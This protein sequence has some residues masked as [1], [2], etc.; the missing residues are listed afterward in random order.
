MAQ[1][2]CVFAQEKSAAFFDN[3]LS[4]AEMELVISHIEECE[5]CAQ[6]FAELEQL[7]IEAPRLQLAARDRIDDPQYWDAM[8]SKIYQELDSAQHEPM[9][10][11]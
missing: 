10:D 6:M 1:V 11:G 5:T 9:Y 4:Q 3:Q 7:E 2:S 8:D